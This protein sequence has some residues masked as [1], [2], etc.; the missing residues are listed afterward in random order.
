MVR[1][2]KTE[3]F[4]YTWINFTLDLIAYKKSL[5]TKKIFLLYFISMKETS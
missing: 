1:Q 4:D 5:Q 3:N 2:N